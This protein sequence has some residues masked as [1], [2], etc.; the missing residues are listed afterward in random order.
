L[1]TGKEAATATQFEEIRACCFL[2]DGKHLVTVDSQGVLRLYSLPGLQPVSEMATHLVT[3]CA[4]ISPSGGV[5][6]LGCG[7]GRVYMVMIDGFDESALIVTASQVSRRTQT[8]LQRLMGKSGVKQ[9][10]L[11][12]C[13]VCRQTFEL[14]QGVPTQEI[15][16]PSCQRKLLISAVVS[17]GL[18]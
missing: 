11:C 18:E 10:F 4:D 14:N 17:M 13:P 9:A 2:R 3:Q 6:A 1:V 8:A 12:H 16:C 5:I 15:G 7:D